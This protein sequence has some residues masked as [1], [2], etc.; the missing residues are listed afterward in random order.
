MST[1]YSVWIAQAICNVKRA[2][3][4]HQMYKML[5]CECADDSVACVATMSIV[6]CKPYGGI[7]MQYHATDAKI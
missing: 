3:L 5:V 6:C 4:Y 7:S 2:A 1:A